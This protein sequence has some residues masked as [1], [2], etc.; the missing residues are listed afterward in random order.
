ME[1]P[2]KP[3]SFIPCMAKWFINKRPPERVLLILKDF[4]QVHTCYLDE[5]VG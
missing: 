3:K 5:A 4:G 1:H 2:A